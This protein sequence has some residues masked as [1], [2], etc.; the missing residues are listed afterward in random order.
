MCYLAITRCHGIEIPRP[1]VQS[2]GESGSRAIR[3][4]A[5]GIKVNRVLNLNCS[6][7]QFKLAR[8]VTRAEQEHIVW[9]T[10]NP[11]RRMQVNQNSH[12]SHRALSHDASKLGHETEEGMCEETGRCSKDC[13]GPGDAGQQLEEQYVEGKN[14]IERPAQ[15]SQHRNE[16][17]CYKPCVNVW[18][19][20]MF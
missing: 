7:I 14:P 16:W 13:V 2:F 17:H 6:L 5:S 15:R 9:G 4:P 1:I 12:T 18:Q 10:E 19:P 11:Q 8:Q 3:H 20:I